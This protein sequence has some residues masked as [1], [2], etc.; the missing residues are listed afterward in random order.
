MSDGESKADDEFLYEL[1]ENYEGR[2]HGELG[3]YM[4]DVI[5][6]DLVQSL[7]RFQ[8]QNFSVRQSPTTSSAALSTT[9]G[10]NSDMVVFE[11]VAECFPDKGNAYEIKEKYRILTKGNNLFLINSIWPRN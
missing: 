10:S 5:L 4:N 9:T 2:V 6:V 3:G 8:K 1:V 7:M 11:K